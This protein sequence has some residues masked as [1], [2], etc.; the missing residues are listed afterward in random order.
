MVAFVVG[1]VLIMQNKIEDRQ[2]EL[3]EFQAKV[4]FMEKSFKSLKDSLDTLAVHTKR[5]EEQD[6]IYYQKLLEIEKQKLGMQKEHLDLTKKSSEES[7]K[8]GFFC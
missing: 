3:T 4:E 8:R 7:K 2:T 6:S 1:A 5:K